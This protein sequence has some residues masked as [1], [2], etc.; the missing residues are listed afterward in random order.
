MFECSSRHRLHQPFS[1]RRLA[2]DLSSQENPQC[3]SGCETVQVGELAIQFSI[4]SKDLLGPSVVGPVESSDRVQHHQRGGLRNHVLQIL[5]DSNLVF[6][7]L[8]PEQDNLL[9]KL[10]PSNHTF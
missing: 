8:R 5:D 6:E 10:S 9:G 7:I 4:A 3:E 1:S 2:V